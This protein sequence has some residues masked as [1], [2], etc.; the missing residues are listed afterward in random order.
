MVPFAKMPEKSLAQIA[1]PAVREA[2]KEADISAK[3]VDAVFCGTAFGGLLAGQRIMKTLG[4]SG[5]PII[6]VE[7]AC[8]S[9]SSAFSM[10]WWSIASGQHDIVVVVGAEKLTEFGGGTLP[11]AADD[12]EVRQ[13]M[14]MPALYAMRAV[15]E[16]AAARFAAENASAADLVAIRHAAEIFEEEAHDAASLARANAAF[17]ESI[18]QTARNDYLMRMLEDLNDSLALLP[19]TT[20]QI[21]GRSEEAKREHAAILDAI[22]R[23]DADAAEQAMRN[24]M[25]KA[26]AGRL[27]LPDADP[28]STSWDAYYGTKAQGAAVGKAAAGPAEREAERSDHVAGA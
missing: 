12:W 8:S 14:V 20:F 6:N 3:Q 27:K 9:S 2:V 10:A 23:R 25:H 7:N 15:L 26:L 13:G 21:P 11:L 28:T 18:Y 4:I 5:M 24:H 19:R 16:G 17:H 1:S 22:E